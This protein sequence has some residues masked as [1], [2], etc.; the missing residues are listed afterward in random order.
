M[1][2]YDSSELSFQPGMQFHR[3]QVFLDDKILLFLKW[4]SYSLEEIFM[5]LEAYLRTHIGTQSENLL[6]NP[7]AHPMA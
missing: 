6:Q 3:L 1:A 2:L 4:V 7:N 5:P